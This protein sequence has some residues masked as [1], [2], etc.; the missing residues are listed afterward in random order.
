MTAIAITGLRAFR[1]T[2]AKLALVH[3]DEYGSEADRLYLADLDKIH[4]PALQDSALDLVIWPVHPRVTEPVDP[5]L[6]SFLT[7]WA[8]LARNSTA[9]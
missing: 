4:P 5:T 2:W 6:G 7:T 8:T 9:K 1:I 3:L